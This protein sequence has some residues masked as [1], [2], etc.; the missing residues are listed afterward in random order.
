MAYAVGLLTTDGCLSKDGRHIELTSKDKDQLLNLMECLGISVKIGQKISG[1][2]GK[3][4]GHI[5]F[6][7]INFY[8][9]LIKIG[10]FPAKTKTL[11]SLKI[12]I[13]YF[14]DFLRGHYDGDGS[15][16]SYWDKRWKSSFMFYLEFTSASQN[17]ILWLQS[18][19]SKST[20]AKGHMTKAAK[21]SVIQ[22]KYAKQESLKLIQKMYYN[23]KAICL[24]RKLS[25]IKQ[26]LKIEDKHNCA[27]A[28]VL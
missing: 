3:K 8:R 6:G 18:Q 19:I 23:E 13:K 7:D 27:K 17:H 25:K 14:F 5:Q 16:Y 1:F 10:L 9:F 12:P 2:T 4:T 15:F 24:S 22:L 21:S 28:R 20:G 26:A 11:S